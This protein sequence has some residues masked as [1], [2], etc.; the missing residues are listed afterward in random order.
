M[1]RPDPSR[2]DGIRVKVKRAW[3]Q[4]N[5][6]KAEITTFIMG[7]VYEPKIEFNTDTHWLTISVHVKK[8]PPLMWGVQ[9]GE[10]IHNLRSALDH[11]V[12]ELFI[13]DN[14]RHPPVGTK[15]QF[16]IFETQA[17]FDG[18]GR[19]QFLRGIGGNAVRL[20]R[21]QQ[22]F[23]ESEGGTGEGRKSPLWHLKELSNTDKHRTLHL[24]GTLIEKFDFTFPPVKRPIS[25]QEKTISNP[26]PI[27]EDTILARVHIPGC[28]VWPFSEDHVN[29]ELRTDIAFDHGTPSVGGW[30]VFGTLIDIAN[31]TEGI[32]RRI[33]E[34][35]FG[36]E[37]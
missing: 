14:L 21:S 33:T 35:I 19:S 34:E 9:I 2:L 11:I 37:L 27:Y 4:I 20:I 10:I 28:G 36:L 1:A 23:P 6:I 17:G 31:R 8:N 32:I 12:W 25:I 5:G 29:G 22:P 16:P 30:L 24:T 3:N 15:L 13:L 7:D 18:R 26:G